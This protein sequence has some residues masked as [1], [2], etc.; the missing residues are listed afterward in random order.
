MGTLRKL[1]HARLDPGDNRR[2]QQE[3]A[4]RGISTM[5]CAG[6]FLRE[7]LALRAEMATAVSEPGKPGERHTGLIHSLL[8]RSEE[9]L[10]AT[11]EAHATELASGQRRLESMVDRFVQLYLAH[12]PEIPHELR[13]GAGASAQRRYGNYRQTVSEF[14]ANG[15]INGN[16]ADPL[17]EDD[18]G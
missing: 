12:T 6:D 1:L 9:R 18:D 3:A 10:A 14:I 2:L 16:I 13:A 15:G 8:A 11:F 17:D 5:A 4:A 7:Y